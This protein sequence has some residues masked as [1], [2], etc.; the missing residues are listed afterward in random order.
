MIRDLRDSAMAW[1]AA[2]GAMLAVVAIYGIVYSYGQFFKPLG[3]T[4]GLGEAV[5]SIV[6][7]IT[8]LAGFG[9][10]IVSGPL[11]D[12]FGPRPLLLLGAVSLGSGLVLTAMAGTLWQVLI[13]SGLGIGLSL[14][15]VYVPVL[16]TIG[17]WFSR[18]RTMATGLVVTGVGLGTL[19]GPPVSAWLIAQFGWRMA[20]ICLASGGAAV[21]LV[22][23]WL[24]APPPRP[25]LGTAAAKS[26]D[27]RGFGTL[28]LATLL[29]NVVIYVPYVHLSYAAQQ[30]GIAPLTAASLVSVIGASNIAGRLVVAAVASRLGPLVLFRLCHMGFCLSLLI[31]LVADG[32]GGFLAFALLTGVSH[33]LYSA[34]LPVVVAE[35]FGV[36]HLGK[37]LG[38]LFTA[39][40]L[41]SAIGPPV[42]GYLVQSSGGYTLALVV[43]GLFGL[44]ACAVLLTYR[45]DRPVAPSAPGA[46]E[47]RL[48]P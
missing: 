10:S 15:C 48:S 35:Q 1:R 31:W 40:G 12:R 7:S 5:G 16:A 42:T 27:G 11:L 37:T 38:L 8:S 41:G 20:Y 23:A 36:A 44:A 19:I 13:G 30:T 17:Q 2:I 45:P 9:L 47:T 32:Y 6:F 28:Y 24:I 21:L 3:Q 14:A 22:S 25:M 4:L 26:G 18:Y 29:I 33:G 46:V 39:L 43:L 34:L